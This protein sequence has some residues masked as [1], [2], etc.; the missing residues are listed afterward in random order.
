MEIL[1]EG[2]SGSA[3]YD[4]TAAGGAGRAAQGDL[5]ADV[6]LPSAPSFPSFYRA[7]IASFSTMPVA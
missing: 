6:R 4:A 3:A 1:E 7:D 5:P 2:E